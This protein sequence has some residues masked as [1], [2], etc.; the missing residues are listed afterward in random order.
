MKNK[1][2]YK[3]K[4]TLRRYR[5]YK[6]II[7]GGVD[8]ILIDDSSID[9][10]EYNDRF[11]TKREENMIIITDTKYDNNY[12]YKYDVFIKSPYILF[13]DDTKWFIYL[14]NS[15]YPYINP[16]DMKTPLIPPTK[17]FIEGN[18]ILPEKKQTFFKFN[19]K[20]VKI[21]KS[22]SLTRA[23]DK[24]TELNQLLKV[25]C[26]N[27]LSFKL[28]Y[29]YN[30]TGQISKFNTFPSDI[31]LCLY[32]DEN[33][34]SSISL[35]FTDNN[36]SLALYSKTNE[37]FEGNKFNKLLRAVVVMI[38]GLIIYDSQPFKT[39][40][41]YAI[42]PISAWLLISNYDVTL[43]EEF[44]DYTQT[45]DKNIDMEMI[46]N[47]M[48]EGINISVYLDIKKNQQKAKKILDELM[49]TSI[50][51][52][53]IKK[54]MKCPVSMKRVSS[55]TKKVSSGSKRVSSGS[56]R[57]SSGSKKVSSGSKKVSS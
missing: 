42:N 24:I 48:K 1:K 14:I 7:G 11:K 15:E 38:G 4:K 36:N 49:S 55:G 26:N 53:E 13:N 19:I 34:I 45:Q 20:V 37:L 10:K 52:K 8:D 28:D 9:N 6:K 22:I 54:Q 23:Q 5:K 47:Y 25:K 35:K 30:M 29:L 46:K 31:I 16:V 40:N 39:I 56:K 17:K 3:R 21:I 18:I 33:C 44:M 57:V 2:T 12:I 51:E 27:L 50:D 41:S 32:Y 43:D